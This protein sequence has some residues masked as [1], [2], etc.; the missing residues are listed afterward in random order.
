MGIPVFMTKI[1]PLRAATA[2]TSNSWWLK[3]DVGSTQYVPTTATTPYYFLA[4]NKS[5]AGEGKSFLSQIA[6]TLAASSGTA[7]T[8][9]L[10]ANLKIVFA[11][12]N[13]VGQTLYMNAQLA[14]MLGLDTG[15][16]HLPSASFS[17]PVPVG[18]GGYTA[19]YR[20]PWL[21]CPEMRVSFTEPTMFDPMS[22]AGIETSAGS[23]SRAPDGTGSYTSNGIQTDAVFG[24]NAIEGMYRARADYRA[25]NTHQREDMQTWWEN[26]PGPA[27]RSYLI[28]RD[29][30]L[31]I[32]TAN[33]AA[34][35][36][37][38]YNYVEYNPSTELHAA[39]TIGPTVPDNLLWWTARVGGFL[40]RRGEQVYT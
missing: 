32:G 8:A 38:P 31:L 18:V 37:V 35:S 40:T 12:N 13:G 39:P 24:F 19:P 28:W 15:A 5:S 14:W 2:T 3:S 1:V 23:A 7:W 4:T 29:K 9:K 21:W 16:T 27:G 11:H 25:E 30:S 36:A 20:S 6:D 22:C 34:G 26:G 10:N 17:V 33:P